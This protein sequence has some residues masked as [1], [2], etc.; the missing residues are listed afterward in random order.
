[1]YLVCKP[2]TLG[3]GELDVVG[4]LGLPAKEEDQA[5][6]GAQL[7]KGGGIEGVDLGNLSSRDS[8]LLHQLVEDGLYV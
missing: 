7:T 1:M 5:M 4:R 6:G 2:D 8:D 3:T